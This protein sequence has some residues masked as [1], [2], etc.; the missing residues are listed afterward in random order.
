MASLLLIVPAG[1]LMFSAHPHEFLDNRV[2]LLKLM[3][4]GAAGLNAVVFHF[5]A[6]RSVTA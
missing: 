5:G 1:L 3:L 4:I 6:Y 2:F